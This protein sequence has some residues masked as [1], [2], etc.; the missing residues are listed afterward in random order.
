MAGLHAKCTST[1]VRASQIVQQLSHLTFPPA[2]RKRSRFS[3]S[4]PAFC[5]ITTFYFS[6]CNRCC[7]FIMVLAHISLVAG[8]VDAFSYAFLLS[9]CSLLKCLFLSVGVCQGYR[10]KTSETGQLQQSIFLQFWRLEASDQGVG[11]F[12]FLL[13]PLSLA[14]RMLPSH[15]LHVGFLFLCVSRF[16]CLMRTPQSDQ[17][18][19]HP[20]GLM[21][22]SFTSLMALLPITVTLGGPG[23]QGF[24]NFY[25]FL[26]AHLLSH[27]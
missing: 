27:V 1:L 25:Q 2:T 22:T 11:G 15:C 7:C 10:N 3:T 13:G 20:N 4:S 19:T 6:C 21:L 8:H 23:C 17:S 18:R 16:P 14:C 5:V 24:F 12:G 26:A 9:V